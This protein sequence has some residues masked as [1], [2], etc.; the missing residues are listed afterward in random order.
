MH[1]ISEEEF[2]LI[3]WLPNSKRVD[4]CINPITD[5]FF[6]NTCPFYLN[7]IFEF[8]PHYRIGTR[9]NIFKLKNPFC[10]TNMGQK[11]ISYIGPSIWISLPD[12]NK[13]ASNL[14]AFKHNVKK[15]YLT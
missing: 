10:K 11:R 7:K 4:Q 2:R 12:S 1:H 13:K 15:H 9:N 3:N 6:N 14:N 8:A 5:N